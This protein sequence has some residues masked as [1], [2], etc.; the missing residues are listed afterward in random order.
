MTQVF[1]V[2]LPDIGEGVVEGEVI[3]WLKSVGDA[4]AK[5]EP[6]VVVMTD[7]A[8]VE[9]PAPYP[10]VLSQQ[11]VP[12]GKIGIKDKPLYAV[13]LA[14]DIKVAKKDLAGLSGGMVESRGLTAVAAG[15]EGSTKSDSNCLPRCTARSQAVSQTGKSM[16][17]PAVR[18]LAKQLSV[19]LSA[20]TGSG[21]GGRVLAE[22]LRGT[23]SSI[24]N[25][26]R[27]APAVVSCTPALR[28]EG[29]TETP[30]VGFRRLTAEKMVEAKYIVPHF[31]YFDQVDATRLVQLRANLKKEGQKEGVKVTF[32]PFFIKALSMALTRYRV[33]NS[34]VDIHENM[35]LTHKP[36]NIG[37]AMS[38]PNGLVVP[39]IKG[40]Q[41]MAL[42]A[43]IRRFAELKGKALASAVDSQD[44]KESTITISNFG[45]LGGGG[46]YATPIINYPEVA[47][48]GVAKIR[49][50]PVVRNDQ[51]AIRD[52]LNVSW[53]FDH[54]IIDGDLAAEFS[55]A[56]CELIANPSKML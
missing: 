38:G 19:D 42:S 52:M 12:A 16:A 2:V 6:V 23:S 39:V 7:K 55:H 26:G 43:V 1:T 8:T 29:D 48:L 35:I 46:V 31:A 10:G 24:P 20:V 3:E 53:S 11:Y 36:H 30:I 47:I 45:T 54:R 21:D 25:S 15:A 37:I 28:L 9:L 27:A 56:F 41:E 44:M 17:T 22:D 50:Q 34:S 18:H 40:V 49:K 32:M 51:L 13:D 14:D 5:D 4:V 33:V